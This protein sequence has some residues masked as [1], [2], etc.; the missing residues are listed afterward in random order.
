MKT[1]LGLRQLHNHI[2]IFVIV[3]HLC[4]YRKKSQVKQIHLFNFIIILK[5]N[6]CQFENDQFIIKSEIFNLL[7]KERERLI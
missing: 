6:E 7:K 3:S 1:A 2:K 5:V 4:Q